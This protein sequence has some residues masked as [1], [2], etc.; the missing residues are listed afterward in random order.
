MHA[1]PLSSRGTHH[2]H[3]TGPSGADTLRCKLSTVG[4]WANACC[5]WCGV[6]LHHLLLEVAGEG[7]HEL[8]RVHVL[9]RDTAERHLRRRRGD[10]TVHTL[11]RRCKPPPEVLLEVNSYTASSPS[12]RTRPTCQIAELSMRRNTT[13]SAGSSNNK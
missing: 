3:A 5:V 2:L 4:E 1:L 11:V 13:Q 7:Q 10:Q 6:H 12:Y 9:H 8:M